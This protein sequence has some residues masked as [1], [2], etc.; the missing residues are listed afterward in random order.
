VRMF[1]YIAAASL[2]RY[3]RKPERL[4]DEID[5]LTHVN[6]ELHQELIEH[7]KK[8]ADL[9]RKLARRR[10]NPTN[11]STHPYRRSGG[12]GADAGSPQKE[13]PALSGRP[14][15]PSWPRVS[16]ESRGREPFRPEHVVSADAPSNA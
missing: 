11:S 13:E 16:T 4:A 10:Q 1:G 5:R 3:R 15:Q 6:E 8:I 2:I 9:E 12:R 14:A 7:D